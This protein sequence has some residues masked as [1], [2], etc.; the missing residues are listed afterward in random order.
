MKDRVHVHVHASS[1]F[2]TACAILDRSIL[3][4][5]GLG[6]ASTVVL[7]GHI[8]VL[9]KLIKYSCSGSRTDIYRE[10]STALKIGTAIFCDCFGRC[11]YNIF[12][13]FFARL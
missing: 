7:W 5:K 13:S 12:I 2:A 3:Y 6:R 4:G 8:C 11:F 10:L 1:C 9:P